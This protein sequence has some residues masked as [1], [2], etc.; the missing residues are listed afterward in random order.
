LAHDDVSDLGATTQ[1]EDTSAG[2]WGAIERFDSV[3]SMRKNEFLERLTGR[4]ELRGLMGDTVLHQAVE[5]RWALGDRFV[6]MRFREL[7]G[8]PY[9]A[10]YML[11]L[12]DSSATY[13]LILA[14]STGVYPN[15]SAVVGIGQK[16]GDAVTLKFGDPT[17]F[18]NRFEWHEA[19]ASWSHFLTSINPDG[20]ATTFAT[21]HLTRI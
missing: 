14:D 10:A 8:R 12:D 3:G 13:V 4:W 16:T 11:G 20:R 19:D 15:P 1:P 18:M 7:D 17:S 2:L 6:E 9:E 21:K 5:S